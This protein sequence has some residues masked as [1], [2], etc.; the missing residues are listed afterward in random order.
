[1]T[2]KRKMVLPLALAL[3][4]LGLMV[5]AQLASATHPRPKGATPVAGLAGRGIQSMCQPEP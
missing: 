5:V 2:I 4:A 1:M 3:G